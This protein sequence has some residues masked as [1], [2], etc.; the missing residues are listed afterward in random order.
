M[1]QPGI[2]PGPSAWQADTLPRHYKSRLLSQGSTSVS[3][4]YTR[5]HTNVQNF[6]EKNCS[7]LCTLPR[8]YI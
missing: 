1:P 6:M 5:W 7:M 8:T 3:Y 4:T 2:E